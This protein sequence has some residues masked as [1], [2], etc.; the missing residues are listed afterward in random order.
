MGWGLLW[1][2]KALKDLGQIRIEMLLS[3]NLEG[4]WWGDENE[5]QIEF[6]DA[7]WQVTMHGMD[8]DAILYKASTGSFPRDWGAPLSTG[9]YG[10]DRLFTIE[11]VAGV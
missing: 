2:I 11:G 10:V 9:D 3:A 6:V 5:Q 4:E 7:N 8:D 1:K